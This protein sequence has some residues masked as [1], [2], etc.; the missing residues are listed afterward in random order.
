VG[1]AEPQCAPVARDITIAAAS[2]VSSLLSSSSV[3]QKTVQSV[4]EHTNALVSDIVQDI[5]NDVASTI[6]SM[7]TEC[8]CLL[9]RIRQYASPFDQLDSKYKRDSYFRKQYGMVA[10]K[11][12]FLGNRFDQSL[13]PATG[14]MRQVIKRDTFQYVPVLKLIELLLSDYSIL[15]ETMNVRISNDGL[16]HDFCDG[17]LF[18][19]NPLFAEDSSALQLC[20]YYD[21]YEV[22]NPQGSRKGIHKIGFIYLSLRN[23]RPMFNSRLSN[24]HILAAFN[25]LDRSKYGFEKILSPIVADLKQLELGVDFKMRDGTVVHKRGTVV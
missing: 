11:S 5:V 6:G 20:L 7:N 22:V 8:E 1:F 13:D 12:V 21:E 14:S 2:F 25:C 24:I 19:S 16:M 9:N 3:T 18:K 15:K 17:S 23:V 4:V 10:A